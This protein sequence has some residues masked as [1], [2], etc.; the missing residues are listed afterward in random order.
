MADAPYLVALA[1]VEQQGK[2]LLPLTGK[3]QSAQNSLA[4]QPGEEGST[5]ALELLLRLWQRSDDGAIQRAA[6]EDSLLLVELPM[7]V[8]SVQLPLLKA[9]W[10]ASGD[11][12]EFL[13]HLRNHLIRG[14]RIFIAKYEPVR[15]QP[16]G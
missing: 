8:M 16:W 9:G 7:E 14:W 6:R 1:L 4:D 3:S 13:R 5:L 10:L 15:F 11:T 2:R 12:P